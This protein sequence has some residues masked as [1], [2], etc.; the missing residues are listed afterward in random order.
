M[1]E[2]TVVNATP[3]QTPIFRLL[4]G[5]FQSQPVSNGTSLCLL[6][7]Y[8]YAKTLIFFTVAGTAATRAQIVAQ[9]TQ[10]RVVLSGREIWIGSGAQLVALGAFYSQN[11]VNATEVGFLSLAFL[12]QWMAGADQR[13]A[14]VLGTMDQSA[15]QIEF[16][17]GAAITITTNAAFAARLAEGEN[18][19]V[20]TRVMRVS[21]NIGSLGI[22]IYPDLPLPR[23]GETLLA[24]HLFPPVVA[25]LTNLAYIADDMRIIDAPA[26]A[27]NRM[28]LETDPPRTPQG[29]NGMVSIDFT[30]LLASP[31]SGVP[32]AAI[33][34]HVLELTFATAAPGSFPIL[35]EF[36]GVIPAGR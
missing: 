12:R 4:P 29:A 10:V 30:A 8:T 24:L 22:S 9:L 34:N 11:D 16:S 21:P 15:L 28:Y 25:N 23:S 26:T 31:Q 35:C 19:G 3:I 1:P 36:A 33:A 17:W 32:M 7:L 18:T 14:S 5:V 27:L 13:L 6:P 20:A 2:P